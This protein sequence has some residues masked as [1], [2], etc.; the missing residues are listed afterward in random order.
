MTSIPSLGP[1]GEGWV[2]LQFACFGLIAAAWW[3]APAT[4]PGVLAP[5]LQAAGYGLVIV[6][7]VLAGS[8]LVVLSRAHALATVPY[9]RRDASLVQAGP[10]GIVR[11]PI[12]AGLI[13]GALGLAALTPWIGSLAAAVLLGVVLDLKR[14]R[15]ESWLAERFPGYDDY[16]RRTRA[17]VPF[18]Y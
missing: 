9:P 8:G 10:Y 5:I 7:G 2:V 16:R 14:R 3:F 12:Y 4:T 11:H 17:L 18:V 1:R 13:S 6:G 15:E